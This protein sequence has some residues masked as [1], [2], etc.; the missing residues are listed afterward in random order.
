[1]MVVSFILLMLLGIVMNLI[2]YVAVKFHSI[3]L[4]AITPLAYVVTP[5]VILFASIRT[6][7]KIAEEF[8]KDWPKV[9]KYLYALFYGLAYFKVGASITA[10]MLY[11]YD[12]QKKVQNQVT[13]LDNVT[14][15]KSEL[16][17]EAKKTASWLSKN[18]NYGFI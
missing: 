6:C 14:D 10:S 3:G 16:D 9:G 17:E 2:G 11:E 4:K 12:K 7:K 1:M 8:H 18:P 5:M 15:V 13:F